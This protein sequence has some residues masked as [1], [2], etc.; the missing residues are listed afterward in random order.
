MLVGTLGIAGL[1]A[2][3][4]IAIPVW[5]SKDNS[6]APLNKNFQSPVLVRKRDYRPAVAPIGSFTPRLLTPEVPKNP[7]TDMDDHGDLLYLISPDKAKYREY[8][9]FRSGSLTSLGRSSTDSR[10][11]LSG[12]G[13]PLKRISSGQFN[14][15]SRTFADGVSSPYNEN[16]FLRRF[17]D[18]G[19][20]L[21]VRFYEQKRSFLFRLELDL[22]RATK[23]VLFSSPHAIS[24]LERSDTG[25][26]WVR[27]QKKPSSIKDYTLWKID[28]NHQIQ[29]EFPDNYKAV[30]RVCQTGH[31]IAA[32]FGN[33]DA[34]DPL[35]SYIWSGDNWKE[36]PLPDG[37]TCSFVQKVMFDGLI[38]GFVTDGEL[39]HFRQVV[40][41]GQKV[42]ILDDLP[43]WPKAGQFSYI[44]Q[45]ARNGNI[46]VRDELD[47]G[48]GKSDYYLLRVEK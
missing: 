44:V 25:T 38:L 32:T 6:V 43:N 8:A 7:I 10:Y 5:T 21:V 24:L 42:A 22:D 46:Y 20:S 45:A 34:N 2:V 26:M 12:N 40:W 23:K 35:R 33:I 9:V 27:E 4:R 41:D 11:V 19:T 1:L 48:T 47:T 16:R 17:L 29:V 14:S 31:T 39:K 13:T 28:G 18:D 37:Y 36:L 3:G 30:D 15:S